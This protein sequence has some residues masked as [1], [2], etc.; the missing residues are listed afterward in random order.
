M[1]PDTCLLPPVY[2]NI[3]YKTYQSA[4]RLN[5]AGFGARGEKGSPE[6]SAFDAVRD[7]AAHAYPTSKPRT[8]VMISK[9]GHVL[10]ITHPP[11]R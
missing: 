5:Q 11:R 9:S 6:W 2:M 3:N 1:R 7:D 4:Q 10:R 8:P